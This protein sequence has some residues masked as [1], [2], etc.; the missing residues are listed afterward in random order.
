M[1][2]LV[3]WFETRGGTFDS[4]ALRFAPID[5]LGRAA[6]AVRDLPVR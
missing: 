4:S 5:G 6:V 2:D 3:R 1:D